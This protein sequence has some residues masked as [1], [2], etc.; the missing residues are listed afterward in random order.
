MALLVFS[1]GDYASA[2][3]FQGEDGGQD[4]M[5]SV[6]QWRFCFSNQKK[7]NTATERAML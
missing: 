6:Y 1:R 2:I 3:W 5:A 4:K 7:E